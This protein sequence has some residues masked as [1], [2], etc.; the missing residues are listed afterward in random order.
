M[1]RIVKLYSDRTLDWLA[2]MQW[3]HQHFEKSP[4]LMKLSRVLQAESLEKD[5]LYQHI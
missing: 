3:R 1:N 4:T 5:I 2:D